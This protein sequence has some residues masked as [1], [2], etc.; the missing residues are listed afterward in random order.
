MISWF[1]EKPFVLSLEIH[2]NEISFFKAEVA[3]ICIKK[4]FFAKGIRLLYLNLAHPLEKISIHLC[5]F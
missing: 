4:T 1:Q 3:V 5:S 2:K